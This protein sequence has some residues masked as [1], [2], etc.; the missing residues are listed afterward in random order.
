MAYDK[1]K[2]ES[3][4]L[5][6]GINSKASPYVN[7]IT[8]FRD[9]TNLNFVVPGALTQRSGTEHYLGATVQGRVTGGVEFTRLNGAS[10]IVASANTNLYSVTN[11]SWNAVKTGLTSNAIFS[12]R[13]LVDRLFATNGSQFFK[14]DGTN[15]TNYSLPP[16]V[17][18]F[19]L[20]AVM[21]GSLT[22]GTTG[23]FLFSYGYV[24]DRGYFGPPND[25][26]TITIDGS[27]DNSVK[28]YGLTYPLGFG[29]TAIALYRTSSGG[30]DLTFTTFAP[31]A[32]TQVT[33]IGFPLSSQVAQFPLYFTMAP[34]YLEIYNNQLILGGFSSMLST[35]FWSDIGEPESVQPES[36]AEVRTNDGDRITGLKAYNGALVIS[37]ERS[38]HRLSGDNPDNFL[39]QEVS[40]QYGCL[41]NNAMVVWENYLWFLDTKGIVEYNGANIKIVSNKVEPIFN[42]MNIAAARENAV[43]IHYRDRNE[44]WFGIPCNGASMNNCV[45]VYDYI[46]EAWT[47]Y[48]GVDMSALFLA[49]GARPTKTPFF[50]G[51]TGNMFYFDPNVTYD[52]GRAITCMIDTAF[53]A[54]DSQ[55]TEAQWRRFYL[56]VNPIVGVTLPIDINFKANYGASILINRTLYQTPFQSRLDF[57]IP[58]RSIAAQAIHSSAS[59]PI[60][61]FG[62]A[63]EWRF[64]RAV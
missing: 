41:S 54:K 9:I 8:E 38:F 34:K 14:F 63:F 22:I 47:K 53:H 20:T 31:F 4:A 21:G 58:A 52:S 55:T 48:E 32:A 62:Y 12:F 11:L 39:L 18:G 13:T 45:V 56:N 61:F 40:D 3:Y 24:N 29:I 44:V 36:F 28:L 51:Y 49:Q 30:S 19:G 59:Y 25:G 5:L 35:F 46:A 43:G 7:N 6:G 15:V 64:Q 2:V 17:N 10:Y 16:P 1:N 27:T 23:T 26:L 60:K 50:G 37:K 42:T 57:G 33:D